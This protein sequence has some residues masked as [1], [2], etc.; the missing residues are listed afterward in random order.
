[1]YAQTYA[2]GTPERIAIVR[3]YDET[4]KM[5]L[6]IAVCV[7]IPML[8]MGLL[9]KNYKLNEVDQHVTGTVIGNSKERVGGGIGQQG[10]NGDG[11]LQVKD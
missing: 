9:M 4:M 10:M 3:A 1:M 2:M 7:C 6:I 5:L 11:Q 8:P